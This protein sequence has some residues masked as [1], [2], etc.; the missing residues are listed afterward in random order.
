MPPTV[1]PALGGP[2]DSSWFPFTKLRCRAPEGCCECGVS[3]C[4]RGK[5]GLCAA[6]S[7]LPIAGHPSRVHPG[8]W[9]AAGQGARAAG[10]EEAA[11]TLPQYPAAHREGW[12]RPPR[13]ADRCP[14]GHGG[15]QGL[16][17]PLPAAALPAE[18]GMLAVVLAAPWLRPSQAAADAPRPTA[19]GLAAHGSAPAAAPRDRASCRAMLSAEQ[20]A[21]PQSA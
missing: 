14:L 9:G 6:S 15:L 10:A 13:A 19:T 16:R 1:G 7:E 4:P 18:G 5:G 11:L 3:A 12:I 2:A 20:A 8:P 17:I 21:G